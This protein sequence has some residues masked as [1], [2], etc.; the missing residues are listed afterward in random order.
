M[1]ELFF[2]FSRLQ[3][4][5]SQ[6]NAK[7]C[8]N[9]FPNWTASCQMFALELLYCYFISFQFPPRKLF[10]RNHNWKPLTS[11]EPS[12][13]Y[14]GTN[15]W[16]RKTNTGRR[17]EAPTRVSANIYWTTPQAIRSHAERANTNRKFPFIA[18]NR[19][20]SSGIDWPPV[21][22]PRYTSSFV[23]Q[24]LFNFARC[25]ASIPGVI[26]STRTN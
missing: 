2:H 12:N 15:R 7:L 13:K 23:K 19:R 8:F 4:Y 18:W 1:H 21:K 6:R 25:Y 16:R 14:K 17:G 11:I 20:T 5:K 9:L 26:N 22:T 24:F 3:W 10:Y